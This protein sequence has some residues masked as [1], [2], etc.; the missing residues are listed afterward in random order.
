MRP[1]PRE[2][3]AIGRGFRENGS[4]RL[5]PGPGAFFRKRRPWAS[6]AGRDWLL[7]FDLREQI[8]M[9]SHTNRRSFL[10]GASVAGFGIFAQGKSGWAGGV[11]PNET[12][13]IACIG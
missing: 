8:P 12:L 6:P 7:V 2:M 5:R 4:M 3:L 9:E 10:F 13:T 1:R 11:G